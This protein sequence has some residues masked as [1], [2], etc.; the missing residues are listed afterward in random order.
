MSVPRERLR[1][2]AADLAESLFDLL[3]EDAAGPA[4]RGSR[5]DV[6]AE[7]VAPPR[8]SAAARSAVV[9]H[10]LLRGPATESELVTALEKVSGS[11]I[12]AVL[13][14]GCQAGELERRGDGAKARYSLVVRA[15]EI[16]GS[17]PGKGRSRRKS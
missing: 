11:E 7:P 8:P 14:H 17:A 16:L 5:V 13:H 4:A 9:R 1:R 6:A 2:A 15:D 10:I 12:A 3:R